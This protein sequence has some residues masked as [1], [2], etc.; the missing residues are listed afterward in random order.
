MTMNA[1][2]IGF[3]GLGLL[4]LGCGDVTSNVA[5]DADS[6]GMV[7]GRGRSLNKGACF[8]A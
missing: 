5:D 4:L 6:G 1:L 8:D 7:D 2:W 3:L